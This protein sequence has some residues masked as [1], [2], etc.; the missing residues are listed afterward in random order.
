MSL[1]WA[2][3]VAIFHMVKVKTNG[4]NNNYLRCIQ[5][6]SLILSNSNT[7]K[8]GLTYTPIDFYVQAIH[9]QGSWKNLIVT[10]PSNIGLANLKTIWQL[11]QWA[12][13]NQEFRQWTIRWRRGPHRNSVDISSI[14]VISPILFSPKPGGKWRRRHL[15]RGAFRKWGNQQRSYLW[16]ELFIFIFVQIF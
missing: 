5:Y 10:W 14:N 9:I 3:L 12:N 7:S 13:M 6:C 4:R 2:V 15:I 11:E 16:L 1:C 8:N